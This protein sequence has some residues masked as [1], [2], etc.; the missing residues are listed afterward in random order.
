[1][2]A[3][4]FIAAIKGSAWGR[5]LEQIVSDVCKLL[6]ADVDPTSPAADDSVRRLRQ[7]CLEHSLGDPYI[8][9]QWAPFIARV[10]RTDTVEGTNDRAWNFLAQAVHGRAGA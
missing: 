6:D 1:M 8:Y 5:A 7:V 9:A 2:G 10:N 3:E 4:F